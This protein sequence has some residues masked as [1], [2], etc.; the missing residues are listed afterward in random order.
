MNLSTI[1]T[2]ALDTV[3]P[4]DDLKQFAHARE[5]FAMPRHG[6]LRH[7]AEEKYGLAGEDG[8]EVAQLLAVELDQRGFLGLHTEALQHGET[9]EEGWRR[10]LAEVELHLDGDRVARD[11]GI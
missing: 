2:P 9:G 4:T 3:G 10:R 1:A 11:R 7:A 5:L 6:H 8:D